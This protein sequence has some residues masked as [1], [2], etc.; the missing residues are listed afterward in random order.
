MLTGCKILKLSTGPPAGLIVRCSTLTYYIFPPKSLGV[1]KPI[2]QTL[3]SSICSVSSFSLLRNPK[4]NANCL[5]DYFVLLFNVLEKLSLESCSISTRNQCFR[6]SWFLALIVMEIK[7][8]DTGSYGD[9][10]MCSFSSGM[11]FYSMCFDGFFYVI[12]G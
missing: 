9:S 3:G 11:G 6:A 1:S 2:T 10:E 4:Y 8:S 12:I 5:I 7:P